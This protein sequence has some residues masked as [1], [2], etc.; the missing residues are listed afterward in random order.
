LP[1]IGRMSLNNVQHPVSHLGN[2]GPASEGDR[3][4]GLGQAG[5]LRLRRHFAIYEKKISETEP[6]CKKS[7]AKVTWLII[8]ALRS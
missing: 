1:E 2:I 4:E 3:V 7:F 5:K 8:T 6:C